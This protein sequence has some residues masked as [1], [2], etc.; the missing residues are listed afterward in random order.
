MDS[1]ELLARA[2]LPRPVD[3]LAFGIT[4]PAVEVPAEEL[5]RV[6][7][8]CRAV[9][10]STKMVGDLAF[11][12]AERNGASLSVLAAGIGKG[13]KRTAAGRRDTLERRYPDGPGQ[14]LERLRANYERHGG[15][16]DAFGQPVSLDV[17]EPRP[18]EQ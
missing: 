12:L 2:G 15:R 18:V 1:F 4:L 9:S 6:F 11:W 14:L 5:V 10:S 7:D 17:T 8:A 13:Y 3:L 16:L